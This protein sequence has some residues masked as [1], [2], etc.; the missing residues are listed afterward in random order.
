MS[1]LLHDG[2]PLLDSIPT[3][4]HRKQCKIKQSA[5]VCSSSSSCARACAG[6]REL[7][8]LVRRAQVLIVGRGYF[9]AQSRNTK[10]ENGFV[11][12]VSLPRGPPLVSRMTG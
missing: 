11:S 2:S 1:P 5:T 8:H 12:R 7:Q 10:S 6:S 3:D 4:L 9:S